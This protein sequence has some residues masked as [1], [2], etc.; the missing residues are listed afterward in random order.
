MIEEIVIKTFHLSLLTIENLL[1]N[2]SKSYSDPKLTLAM[3][4]SGFA[5]LETLEKQKWILSL[6]R[7]TAELET[8]QSPDNKNLKAEKSR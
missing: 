4:E 7:P 8:L 3:K 6:L 2:D 5:M 1:E